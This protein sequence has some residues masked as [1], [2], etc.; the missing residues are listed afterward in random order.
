[1]KNNL[2]NQIRKNQRI[3][4]GWR[5]GKKPRTSMFKLFMMANYGRPTIILAF[6]FLLHIL[7]LTL[8]GKVLAAL[9]IPLILQAMIVLTASQFYKWCFYFFCCNSSTM[10]S[11]STAST[12]CKTHPSYSAPKHS[13]NISSAAI[14]I[15][16]QCSCSKLC[17]LLL[18]WFNNSPHHCWGECHS[19]QCIFQ[20]AVQQPAVPVMQPMMQFAPHF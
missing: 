16:T 19:G 2:R 11:C 7:P 13:C 14:L 10:C 5:G 17:L 12:N 8:Q 1:M 15:C 18:L 20:W 6:L 4:L 3:Y 9:H